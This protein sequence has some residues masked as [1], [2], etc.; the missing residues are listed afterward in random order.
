[1]G[2][3]LGVIRQRPNTASN[4]GYLQCQYQLYLVV[5]RGNNFVFWY[6]ASFNDGIYGIE[7]FQTSIQGL[8]LC[9]YAMH[10]VVHYDM[11]CSKSPILRALSR[12]SQMFP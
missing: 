2:L 10:Y 11:F 8:T 3:G 1:M 4:V 9:L 6:F 7:R 5:T 12:T